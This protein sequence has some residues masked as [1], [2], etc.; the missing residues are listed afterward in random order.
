MSA[1]RVQTFMVILELWLSKLMVYTLD[2]PLPPLGG[3]WA[4]VHTQLYKLCVHGYVYTCTHTQT[5]QV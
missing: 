4:P 3:S 2:T 1:Q 5:T